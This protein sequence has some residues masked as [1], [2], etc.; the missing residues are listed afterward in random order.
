MSSLFHKDRRLLE[1]CISGDRGAGEAFVRKFSDLVYRSIQYTLTVKH[2][3]FSH[4][5]LEDLH[6]TVFLKLF[7]D[8]CKKLRQYRGKNGCSLANWIRIV[9]TRIVLN[10]IRKKGVDSIAWQTKRFS[11]DEL[12]ELKGADDGPWAQ[13]EKTERER[14]IKTGI[15]ELPPRDR[16]FLVLHF[17]KG[18]TI[19]EVAKTMQLSIDN[20]HTIKHRAIQKLKS[21]VEAAVN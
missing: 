17:E 19:K 5:D 18:L 7:E 12:P 14:L 3:R 10:H 4:N 13:M 2:I 1:Q 11:L 6:N 21:L 20:A 9:T 16:L 15:K 8:N